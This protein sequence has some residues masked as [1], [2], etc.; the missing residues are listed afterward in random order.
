MKTSNVVGMFW[1]I[2][3][4]NLALAT[5]GLWLYFVQE[6]TTQLW[7]RKLWQTPRDLF[8][9]WPKNIFNSTINVPKIFL[10]NWYLYFRLCKL[11][12]NVFHN[13]KLFFFFG[14]GQFGLGREHPLVG[15]NCLFIG[16]NILLEQLRP[17]ESW[18]LIEINLTWPACL[19]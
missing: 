2:C 4:W 8:L 9:I 16:G 17:Q 7:K 13:E 10:I 3:V 15:G 18:K 5:I 14:R 1:A 12:S 19:L 6:Q 11:I